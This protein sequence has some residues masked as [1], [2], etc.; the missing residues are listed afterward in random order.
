[1]LKHN[2]NQLS[3]EEQ[4][5]LWLM[6][7][8][9]RGRYLRTK[10]LADLTSDFRYSSEIKNRKAGDTIIQ[11]SRTP[12]PASTERSRQKKLEELMQ[13]YKEED[14][15]IMIKYIRKEQAKIAMEE[16]RQIRQLQKRGSEVFRKKPQ[17]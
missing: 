15:G 12:Q 1:M 10:Y 2:I 7:D 6:K 13:T 8:F 17:N 5:Q 3:L 11:S 9:A 14:L 16:R 4:D